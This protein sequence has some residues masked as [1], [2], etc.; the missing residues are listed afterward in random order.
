M[1]QRIYTRIKEIYRAN[2]IRFIL[3][4]AT[5]IRLLAV[6]FAKG[7]GM[8]D[9]HFL[10]IESAQSFVDSY[11]Y[12][13]WLPSHREN[14]EGHN[15]F[16]TGIHYIILSFFK[17]LG[18]NDPQIKMYFIRLIHAFYSLLIIYIGYKIA[19]K[20]TEEKIALHVAWLLALVWFFPNSSVRNLVEYVC[21]VPLL[22][23]TL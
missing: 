22:A 14:P 2:P 3:F 18:L 1:A 4:T 11:D 16:Y 5:F 9:D 6:L 21:I 20:L 10:V 15:W 12:N 7:F 19:R 8:H 23:S 13:N 17:W